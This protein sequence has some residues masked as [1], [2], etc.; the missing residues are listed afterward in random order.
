M[1]NQKAEGAGAD[2]RVR[3]QLRARF[4]RAITDPSQAG[5]NAALKNPLF[6]DPRALKQIS[7]CSASG[8][9]G[10]RFL[11]RIARRMWMARLL[12]CTHVRVRVRVSEGV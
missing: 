5:A 2:F 9:S 12:P 1:S 3:V 6:K 11:T 8:E 7:I 10:D 4:V